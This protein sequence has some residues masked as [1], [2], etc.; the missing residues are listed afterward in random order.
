[1]HL[2]LGTSF[3]YSKPVF[4]LIAERFWSTASLAFFAKIGA[5]LISIPVGV[6]CAVYKDTWI[7]RSCSALAVLGICIPNFFLGPILVMVFAL[8][9]DWFPVSEKSDWQSYILPSLTLSLALS[10]FLSR[11]TR[12]VMIEILSE[13]FIRTA[14]AKG[15]HPVVVVLKHGL[16]NALLP[17]STILGLQFG[18]L[19]TGA[20][21]TEKIFDWPGLGGLMVEGIQNRDYPLVQ[22]CVLVFAI[23]YITVNFSTDLL[24]AVIDPRIRRGSNA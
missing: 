7:D 17:L 20:I 13:N 9:L 14:H 8:N 3:F 22:G 10:A 12:N 2:D 16:R 4:A 23:I 1:M 19:L 24:N 21:I 5:I 15:V 18:V 11:M 6:I